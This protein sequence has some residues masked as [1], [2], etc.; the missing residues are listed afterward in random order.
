MALWKPGCTQPHFW[1]SQAYLQ[2]LAEGGKDQRLPG[3]DLTYA[4][5]FFINYAQVTPSGGRVPGPLSHSFGESTL[6][7]FQGYHELATPQNYQLGRRQQ[8]WREGRDLLASVSTSYNQQFREVGT[9]Y[10][11]GCCSDPQ[12]S[13]QTTHASS[14]VVW[15]LQAGV[16]HPVHQDGRP[17]S[18]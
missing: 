10:C 12:A 7:C 17:Q 8:I 15:V 4:Q 14:G 2:W 3:L 9:L 11:K 6:E 18:S 16:R 1:C 5:L 13:N